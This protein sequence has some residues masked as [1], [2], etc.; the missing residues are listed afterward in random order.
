ML[1]FTQAVNEGFAAQLDEAEIVQVDGTV[2]SD[3]GNLGGVFTVRDDSQVGASDL[4]V[5]NTPTRDHN[6]DEDEE[7]YS[8]HPLTQEMPSQRSHRVVPARNDVEID[9][10]EPARKKMNL[11]VSQ[12]FNRCHNFTFNQ[13]KFDF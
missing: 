12:F 5:T 6:Q 9:S 13:C 4:D 2:D 10:E 1:S 11:Q 3:D 8:M 7:D